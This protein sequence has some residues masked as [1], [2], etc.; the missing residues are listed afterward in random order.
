[1]FGSCAALWWQPVEMS[2]YSRLGKLSLAK[3]MYTELP[4]TSFH[5]V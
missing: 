4:I 3:Q 1:M 2:M 5:T